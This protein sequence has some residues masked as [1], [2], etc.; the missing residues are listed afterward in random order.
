MTVNLL[1]KNNISCQDLLVIIMII[2]PIF[3]PL[4]FNNTYRMIAVVASGLWLFICMTKDKYKFKSIVPCLLSVGI[5]AV[6]STFLRTLD[7]GLSFVEAFFKQLQFV[8]VIFYACIGVYYMK[9][10]SRVLPM[11]MWLCIAVYAYFGFKTLIAYQTMPGISRLIVR[12]SDDSMEFVKMGI[13]GYGL[14]YTM[15]FMISVAL[16]VSLYEK[17]MIKKICLL[18]FAMEGGILV[19]QSGYF[20]AN[21]MLIFSLLAFILQVYRKKSIK[22]VI[23]MFIPIVIFLFVAYNFILQFQNE[24]IKLVQGSL[25]EVKVHEILASLNGQEVE[26]KLEGRSIVYQKTFFN[27]LDY[28]I[29]GAYAYGNGNMIG[30]HSTL[31]DLFGW[32][33]L[34]SLA[35]YI[36]LKKVF[37]DL[38]Y[39]CQDKGFYI[40]I[41]ILFFMNGTL[42]TIAAAHG[43]IIFLAIPGAVAYVN[44]QNNKYLI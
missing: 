22:S 8:L 2:W 28:P 15:V 12:S 42:N 16:Y 19:V 9:W 25:Y 30:G 27:F 33:G 26:G 7:N 11:L 38:F 3:P 44:Q 18:L 41:V 23:V 32:F 39:L 4:L 40:L 1:K 5:F 20:I 36:V 34:T 35:F 37:R 14:V 17:K 24:I 29:F 43:V 31:F 13:G 21:I 6:L 10:K